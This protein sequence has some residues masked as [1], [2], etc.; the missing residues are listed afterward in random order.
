[1][2]GLDKPEGAKRGGTGSSRH[3]L[4]PAFRM[5]VLTGA[6][7]SVRM[8]LRAGIDPDA[9]DSQ[10]RSPLILAVSRG[11]LDVCKLL[12]EAGADPTTKDNSGNDALAVA[13]SRGEPAAAQLLHRAR[14][15]R[16]EHQDDDRELNH[17]RAD[18]RPLK[19]PSLGPNRTTYAIAEEMTP[20]PAGDTGKRD[21]PDGRVSDDERVSEPPANYHTAF[22]LS[23]WQEEIETEA[24]PDD[25]SCADEAT[26]LQVAVSR[27]S[28]ID[29]DEDWDDVEIDLP[30]LEHL[31]RSRS[32][33]GTDRRTAARVLFVEALRDGRVDEDRIRRTLAEDD[34]LENTK[35]T[36]IEAN[37]R[38]VLE[39][40]GVVIDDELLTTDG[41]TEITD[42]DEDRFGDLATDAVNL[43]ARLQA[44]ETDPLAPYLKALPSDSPD[45][46][47]RDSTRP[48]SRRGNARG[49]RHDRRKPDGGFKAALGLVQSLGG[50][51]PGA[52]NV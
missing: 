26:T 16:V 33:S 39:D 30:E 52:S 40:L 12:L 22:D 43:L 25:L 15:R 48:E 8:H 51:Y 10:G 31:A 49:A 28:P 1:M 4:S 14:M 46:R 34:R 42:E 50:E 17:A 11:H 21:Q 47:R 6:L 3:P 23:G 37:L 20:R 5:A 45:T 2:R 38:L 41:T 19:V 24:P 35:R 27:H 36:S 7:E 44:S 32:R 13:L 29:T 9:T 18:E